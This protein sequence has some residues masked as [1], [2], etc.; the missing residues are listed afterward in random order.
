MDN[1]A[2]A[3]QVEPLIPPAGCLLLITSRQHFTLPG[4]AALAELVQLQ[5]HVP[6]T[7]A[8]PS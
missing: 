7:E 1:A 2:N 8:S 3:E 6:F 5:T 4:L